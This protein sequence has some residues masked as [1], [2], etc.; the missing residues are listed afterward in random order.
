M[1]EGRLAG[2]VAIVTGSTSGIGEGIARLFAEE[3]ARV[4]IVGRRTEK[5]ENVRDEILAAGGE[6]SFIR[7]DMTEDEDVSAMIAFAI[8]TYGRIDILVN[9]AGTFLH[10]PFI[11]TTLEEWDF[12]MNLD[13]RAYFFTMQKVLPHMEKQGSGVILNVTSNV[14]V[15]P[16]ADFALYSFIKAGLTHMSK[17]VALEYADKGIRVNCLLP[18]AT[19]TEM[20]EGQSDN[21]F[22]ASLVP[23]GRHSTAEEQAYAAVYLVSDESKYVTGS[24]LVVDGGWYPY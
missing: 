12:L 10:K 20:T 14:A 6:A 17:V 18:G 23:M 22:I 8:E 3:G 4:L 11:E 2:K 9:N 7:T 5:G 16:S 15:M 21:D 19:M 1:K 24:S 13:A